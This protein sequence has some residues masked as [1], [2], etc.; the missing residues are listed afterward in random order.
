MT[1]QRQVVQFV[2]A[3]VLPGYDVLDVKREIGIDALMNPAIL[4]TM[5]GPRADEL[6]RL[7]IHYGA[8]ASARDRAFSRI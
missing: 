4:A 1:G 7:R 8:D 2:S 3:A 5:I 6:S